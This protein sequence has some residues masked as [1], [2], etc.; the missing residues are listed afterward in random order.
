MYIKK[1]Y[2][3]GISEDKIKTS[4]FLKELNNKYHHNKQRDLGR[5]DEAFYVPLMVLISCFLN[6]EPHS[7]ILLWVLQIILNTDIKVVLLGLICGYTM[8]AL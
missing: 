7:F 3:E 4:I 8:K 6:K 5:K 1:D 2:Q